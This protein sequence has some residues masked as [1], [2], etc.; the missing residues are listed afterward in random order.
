MPKLSGDRVENLMRFR[1]RA[2]STSGRSKTF[3]KLVTRRFHDAVGCQT[4][5]FRQR[6]NCALTRIQSCFVQ[7]HSTN[8]GSIQ[9]IFKL[10]C[11]LTHGIQTTRR[12]R[13]FYAVDPSENAVN[14][15]AATAAI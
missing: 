10:V 12:G 14:Q 9:Q 2:V 4:E 15:L 7:N 1:I 11:D 13:A 3:K 8:S 6:V 5:T